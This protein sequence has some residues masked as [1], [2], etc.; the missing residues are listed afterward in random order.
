[1]LAVLTFTKLYPGEIGAKPASPRLQCG[2]D[3]RQRQSKESQ[4]SELSNQAAPANGRATARP[5]P[6]RQGLAVHHDGRAGGGIHRRAD[7]SG[8]DPGRLRARLLAWSGLHARA[9]EPGRA[10]RPRRSGDPARGHRA[11]RHGRAAGEAAGHHQGRTQRSRADARQGAGRARARHGPA[12]PA[13]AGPGG[14]RSV[15]GRADGARRG[16]QQALR[17]GDRRRVGGADPRAAA[18]DCR[19][20]SKREGATGGA[21]IAAR[22]AP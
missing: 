14:D 15:P 16:R 7:D 20:S 12:D 18:Q 3:T 9:A 5:A 11:R 17:A 19:A 6:T 22:M 13:D 1:M 10:R 2:G 4:V 21:G 8:G